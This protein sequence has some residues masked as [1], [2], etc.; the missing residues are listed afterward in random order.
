MARDGEDGTN[1]MEEILREVIVISDDEDDE[2]DT[3]SN[4]ALVGRDS[5]VEIISATRWRTMSM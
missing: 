5:S 1:D 4:T 3:I 2:A